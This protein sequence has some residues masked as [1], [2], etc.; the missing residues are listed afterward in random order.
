MNN[1]SDHTDVLRPVVAGRFYP[2]DP[3]ELSREVHNYIEQANISLSDKP[4]LAIVVPHAGYVFSAPVAGYSF[5]HVQNQSPDTVLFVALSHQGVDG[6]CIFNGDY[7]E[8]PLGRIPVDKELVSDL[9][10]EGNPFYS[11]ASPYQFEHSV[12]VNLPFVQTTFPKAKA[13]SILVTRTDPQMCREMGHKIAECLRKNPDKSVLLCVSTDMC[14]YPPYKDAQRIDQEILKTIE[15][16]DPDSFYSGLRRLESEPVSNLHC[17]LC[18][19]AAMLTTIEVARDVGATEAKTLCY[20]NSGDSPYG[21]QNKVVGYGSLAI[22]RPDK[23]KHNSTNS[24]QETTTK[25]KVSS[26]PEF[27]SHD[28]RALL[29]IARQ[30]VQAELKGDSYNPEPPSSNVE[31]ERGVF[32]TLKKG[33]ELRGCLGRFTAEGIPLYQLVKTMAVE[34]ATHDMRFN[35]LSLSELPQVDIQISVLSPLEVVEDV[36][37]I[38]IGKHGLQIRGRSQYGTVCTGTLLP[39]VASERGWDVYQFLDATCFK[40]GLQ[41]D[42]WKDPTTEIYMY[43]AE[44]FGDL[45]YGNPPFYLDE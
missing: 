11:S 44:I 39:Q 38:E 25:E 34:S 13:A 23:N 30:G 20:S 37:D 36:K 7:F 22:Y 2:S 33:D 16:L 17:V 28:R 14:H 3:N 15:T 40:A 6:G 27:S 19:S 26:E 21:D 12:E 10:E 8:T 43:S 4:V 9:L 41:T 42:A 24:A 29:R 32:V 31:V 18:G 35:P 45:D 5:R 1:N